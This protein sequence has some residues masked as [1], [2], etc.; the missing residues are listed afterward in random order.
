MRKFGEEIICQRSQ[1]DNEEK[2]LYHYP[3][4]IVSK[5]AFK[6]YFNYT[7][8]DIVVTIKLINLDVS[9]LLYYIIFEGG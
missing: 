3:R 4:R 1:L 7:K 6:K 2:L 5:E 9:I 8:K